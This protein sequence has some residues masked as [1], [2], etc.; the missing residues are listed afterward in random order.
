MKRTNVIFWLIAM[1]GTAVALAQA[2]PPEMIHY[3]G[4]LRDANGNPREGGF[5]MVFRLWSA[6][7]G[8]D[9]ILVDRH[10]SVDGNE[11][12][13]S[14]GLFDATIGSGQVLDGAGP[15]TYTLLSD[16]F[17]Y[18]GAIWLEI[19]IESETLSPRVSLSSAGYAYNAAYATEAA[20]ATD[21]TNA[22]NALQLGGKSAFEFLDVSTTPQSKSGQL[23]ITSATGYRLRGF[24]PSGGGYFEDTNG[25]GYAFVGHGNYGI[26]AYGSFV[27]GYFQDTDSS[28]YA[29]VG[30]GDYGIAAKG[31]YTG[32]YFKDSNNSGRAYAGY[33]DFGIQGFGDTSRGY[34]SDTAGGAYAYVGYNSYKTTGNGTVS[35][36]QNHPEDAARVIY[37]HAP[38]SS[39]VAVYTR[40][41]ARLEG[42]VARIALDE[43]FCWVTNPDLGLTAHLTPRSPAPDLHVVSVSTT[44]LVVAGSGD[45]EF[46]YMAWG[47]RIGF[48]E[49]PP[50]QVKEYESA[51]PS[52]KDHEDLYA[53]DA[54]LRGYNALSRFRKDE[55]RLA[56]VD[57][58]AIDLSRA[59]AL[60]A[61]I[62]IGIP[63]TLPSEEVP[64]R[65]PDPAAVTV[66]GIRR[67]APS[68]AVIAPVSP[69]ASDLAGEANTD[70]TLDVTVT[71]LPIR[72]AVDEGDVL[73]LDPDAPG[74]LR[75]A[76]AIA[77]PAVI[78][79]AIGPSRERAMGGFEAPMADLRYAIVKA[80]AGY[81]AIRAG[82][83]L[84]TSPTPGHAQLA[85]DALPGTIVGKALEPLDTGTGVIKVLV[86][87]R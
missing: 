59:Q 11:V 78:G 64:A 66:P 15:G 34:F 61:K 82:D 20:F 14:G 2:L 30:Y 9:E 60:V 83:L 29:H 42:G 1:L 47:L 49:L 13:V 53:A 4:V 31:T 86:M 45:V 12:T 57:E 7:T 46:D 37:Y 3:Q 41:R 28:G 77:D 80:D 36:V 33:A 24:G 54:T 73:A 38:E 39:E 50:V 67:D 44:E 72:E 19:Q 17:Y 65:P 5:D 32:G 75:R 16:V 51:I 35:F 62:G 22:S 68:G 87:L 69:R 70:D 58:S 84:T 27:G 10:F 26:S 25:S 63:V 6:E 23:T 85:L 79:I 8:G 43:T 55:A 56:G 76:A 52:M 18:Y 48:E 71:W 74:F 81:G 40:G 21:A